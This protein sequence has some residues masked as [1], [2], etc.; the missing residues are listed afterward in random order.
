[1]GAETPTCPDIQNIAFISV[2]SDWNDP[3]GLM[4]FYNIIDQSYHI[5]PFLKHI[6]LA[7]EFPSIPFFIILDE[8][9]LSKVE[10]YLSDILSV[11][12]T[13]I[14][15]IKTGTIAKEEQIVL[16]SA[17]HTS[18]EFLET[19]DEIFDLIPSRLSI[20]QNIYITGTVNIDE[21]TYML[22]PKVLD[23]ANVIEFNHVNIDRYINNLIKEKTPDFFTLKS[24][25]DFTAPRIPC[26]KY[27]Q[28]IDTE[29]LQIIKQI[30]ALLEKHNIHFGYRVLNEICLYLHNVKSYI[31]GE[32]NTMFKALD[33][34]ILQKILPKLSGSQIK[35]QEP[36]L[37]II[38]IL[39]GRQDISI[40]ASS[41]AFHDIDIKASHY[42]GSL[43]KT[44]RMYEKLI[45]QGFTH[46]IE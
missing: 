39:S 19:N 23:R 31:G 3:S 9:N 11:L 15:D 28:T 33:F 41:D 29:S 42:P 40:D 5:G 43:A 10:F 4:G 8:M 30:H 17:S 13:R 7:R 27:T 21:S 24:L 45:N 35:L 14:P 46:F 6:L 36:L 20:P 32:K 44:V 25:P 34:Q 12:E 2:K 37:G 16:Y 38:K 18:G 22:S 1:M 26:M